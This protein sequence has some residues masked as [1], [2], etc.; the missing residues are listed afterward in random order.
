MKAAIISMAVVILL[1]CFVVMPIM[2]WSAPDLE[3]EKDEEDLQAY[4]DYLAELNAVDDTGTV[5]DKNKRRERKIVNNKTR[6]IAR[7]T[8]II[9]MI[10]IMAVVAAAL[11]G[12]RQSERVSK[13]IAQEADN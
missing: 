6:T 7:V 11:A 13:N 3:D 2:M 10:I 4:Y 12:C 1:F 9:V 8:L 5:P